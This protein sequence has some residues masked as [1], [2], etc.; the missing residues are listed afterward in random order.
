MQSSKDMEIENI[1]AL[2]SF[3]DSA[4]R[5]LFAREMRNQLEKSNYGNNQ[6]KK[7]YDR[8]KIRPSQEN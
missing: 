2:C 8:R 5:Q 4:S 7:E 1:K 3:F 6:K